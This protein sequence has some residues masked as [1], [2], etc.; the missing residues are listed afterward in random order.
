MSRANG[1]FNYEDSVTLKEYFETRLNGVEDKLELNLKLNQIA[2]DKASTELNTR[3]EN[4]NQFRAQMNRQESTY[5]T[6]ENYESRH[7]T[8]INDIN[9]LKETRAELKGRASQQSV[10]IAY[11]IAIIGI[12][13]SM[14]DIVRGI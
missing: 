13:L 11:I 1:N 6:K 7:Q 12:V 2:L 10:Y 8:L 3:L 9:S 5:L 4:M 14:Y